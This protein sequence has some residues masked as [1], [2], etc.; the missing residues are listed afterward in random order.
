MTQGL[1]SGEP[2][3]DFSSEVGITKHQWS[4]HFSDISIGKD[5]WL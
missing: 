2:E 3:K 1:P 4:W 5:I